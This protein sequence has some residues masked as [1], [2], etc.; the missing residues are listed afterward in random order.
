MSR[1]PKLMQGVIVVDGAAHAQK[2]GVKSSGSSF[3]DVAEILMLFLRGIQL[4]LRSFCRCDKCGA[5]TTTITIFT[6]FTYAV[7]RFD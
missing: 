5:T 7:A 2:D 4:V 6:C 3:K 1:F